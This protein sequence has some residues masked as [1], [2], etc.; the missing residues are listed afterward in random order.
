MLSRSAAGRAVIRE[1]AG[2]LDKLQLCAILQQAGV[3]TTAVTGETLSD[4]AL[5]A[6]VRRL[7]LTLEKHHQESLV[8]RCLAGCPCPESP[9][10]SMCYLHS[11]AELQLFAGGAESAP[12]GSSIA[13][14]RTGAR[15]WSA[16]PC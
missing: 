14:D 16:V 3:P 7:T 4:D 15:R 1:F 13:H 9:V 12:N 6:R 8:P 10:T 5:R 2:E 11:D